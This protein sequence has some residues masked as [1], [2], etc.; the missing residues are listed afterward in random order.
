MQCA[1]R[2]KLC[3]CLM[4]G[5]LWQLLGALISH[6]LVQNRIYAVFKTLVCITLQSYNLFTT[7]S[8]YFEDWWRTERTSLPK[9]NWLQ[10]MKPQC[11]K[12]TSSWESIM[13]LGVMPNCNRDI[14]SFEYIVMTSR[15]IWRINR[16]KH[17][18]V[19]WINVLTT[20]ITVPAPFSHYSVYQWLQKRHI[21]E[22]VNNFNSVFHF[23]F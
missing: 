12:R 19:L 11:I 2:T 17:I 13:E 10:S 5:A 21:C 16:G 6:C 20:I 7:F 23:L 1:A 4:L 15:F 22:C 14:S 9:V 3:E 8:I 18:K